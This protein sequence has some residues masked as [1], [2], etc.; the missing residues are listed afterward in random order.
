MTRAERKK[1]RRETLLG[2]ASELESHISGGAGWLFD[3][4]VTGTAEEADTAE[5]YRVE[6][7]KRLVAEIRRKAP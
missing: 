5:D 7:L 6:V 3:F 4:E 1:H 2:A